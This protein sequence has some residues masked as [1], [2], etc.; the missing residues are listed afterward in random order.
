M[1][2]KYLQLCFFVNCLLSSCNDG[3]LKD[4]EIRETKEIIL[5]SGNKD[6]YTRLCIYF[7]EKGDFESSLPYSIVMAYKYNDKDAYY[8]IYRT[9]IRIKIRIFFERIL[10][11]SK[12]FS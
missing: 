5:N 1:K 2:A 11:L 4:S 3:I 12:N 6:L 9:M 8:N 10:P 7:D